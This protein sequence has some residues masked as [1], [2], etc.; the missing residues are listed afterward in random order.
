MRRVNVTNGRILTIAVAAFVVPAGMAFAEPPAAPAAAVAPAPAPAPAADSTPAAAPQRI[1]TLAAKT[2]VTVTPDEGINS[3]KVKEGDSFKLKTTADIIQD[4]IV[5]IPA[6]TPGS[7]KITAIKK[8]GSFGKSG[9]MEVGFTELQLNGQ[10]IPLTGNYQQEG[11][12]NT[13]ATVGAILGAGLIGG[14]VVSGHSAT[15]EHGQLLHAQTADAQQ[16]PASAPSVAK[17]AA[18]PAS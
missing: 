18:V 6:G 16:L 1:I 15:I 4:G 17:P 3:K 9:K 13:G 14:F 12:G 2:D 7:G 8:P 5:V 11:R 10:S